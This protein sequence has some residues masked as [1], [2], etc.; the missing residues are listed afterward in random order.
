MRN[1]S[2]LTNIDNSNPDYLLGRIKDNSGSNDGTP[3][4]EFVYGDIHQFFAKLV[5]EAGIVPNGQPDNEN[6]GYQL[7][8]A[9][10]AFANKNNYVQNINTSGSYLAVSV[11]I[12]L[13]KDNESLICKASVDLGVQTQIKGTDNIIYSFVSIGTFKT[14]EY[15]RLIKTASSI[16][17]VRLVDSVNLDL[18]VGELLYLKKAN[19]T[20]ENAGTSD[21]VATTPLTNKTVF[22]RRVNG[23]DSAT[24]LATTSQNG[25]LSKEDKAIINNIGADKVRNI[26]SIAGVDIYNGTIGTTYAVTGDIVS[27]TLTEKP[28]NSS[29]IRIVLQNTMDDTN[30][31]VRHF[32]ESGSASIGLDNAIGNL[33]FKKI[34]ATTF[35]INI[36]QFYTENQNLKI[37]FEVVKL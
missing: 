19:Q 10:M 18:A 16:I 24:Y 25:L 3:V 17:L 6:N 22:A 11:K 27:G 4:N 26:G 15:V 12:G 34:N 1:K 35:D 28:I 31:Y 8:E 14:D 9:L 13:L 33:V 5:T 36:E 30:Y 37:Y 29:T 7:V 2:T 21:L 20:Q 32:I 23:V